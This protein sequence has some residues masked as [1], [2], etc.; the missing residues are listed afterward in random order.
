MQDTAKTLEIYNE[1]LYPTTMRRSHLTH[2]V[3]NN[4]SPHNNQTIRDSHRD[5]NLHIVGYHVTA[6]EKDEI[7]SLIQQ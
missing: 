2:L 3:E 5:N 4:A 6:A 7:R 1:V